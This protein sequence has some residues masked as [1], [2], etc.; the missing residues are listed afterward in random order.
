MKK[1]SRTC[2]FVKLFFAAKISSQFDKLG[3]R[4]LAIWTQRI[5]FNSTTLTYSAQYNGTGRKLRIH[6][7]GRQVN[8]FTHFFAK[9]TFSG[10]PRASFMNSVLNPMLSKEI[11]NLSDDSDTD[12]ED[13]T[14]ERVCKL[15]KV[16]LTWLNLGL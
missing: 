1:C 4:Q 8:F 9:I 6:G 3:L 16:R 13:Y 15:G 2:R 5:S 10:A 7:A 14:I 12:F 11:D